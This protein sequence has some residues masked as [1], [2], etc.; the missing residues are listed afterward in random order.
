MRPVCIAK[1]SLVKS[2]MEEAYSD[3]VRDSAPPIEPTPVVV[4]NQPP[5][6]RQIADRFLALPWHKREGA[7]K[8]LGVII[9]GQHEI[10]R[11]IGAFRTLARENRIDALVAEIEKA[12]KQ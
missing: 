2:A 3:H 7:L 5:S 1:L 6:Y 9:F 11:Y 8:S 4:I 10:D 12:E